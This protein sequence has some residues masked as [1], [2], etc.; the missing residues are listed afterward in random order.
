MKA[1]KKVESHASLSQ[2]GLST[3]L[4]HQWEPLRRLSPIY[5]Y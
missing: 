2:D 3:Q 5:Y 1:E 4:S